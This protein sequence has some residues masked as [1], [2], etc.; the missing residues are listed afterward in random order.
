MFLYMQY[1]VGKQA[2]HASTHYQ[3][4]MESASLEAAEDVVKRSKF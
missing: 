1:I 2:T 3:D 4:F